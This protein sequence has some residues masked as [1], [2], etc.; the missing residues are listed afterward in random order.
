MT[1]WKFPNGDVVDQK[2]LPDYLDNRF[3]NNRL[4]NMFEDE[5]NEQNNAAIV[6]YDYGG[7][8]AFYEVF[9]NWVRD[10]LEYDPSIL[11]EVTDMVPVSESARRSGSR[12]CASKSMAPTKKAPSKRKA[13]VKTTKGAK[14]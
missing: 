13:P 2:D 9:R 11:A 8:E 10:C 7:Q 12:S 6:L 14:R 4:Y 1:K 5:F 3:P